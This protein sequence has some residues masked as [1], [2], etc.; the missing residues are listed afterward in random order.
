MGKRMNSDLPKV[1]HP[2][3]NPPRPMV[4]AVIDACRAAGC[5]RIVLVIGHRAEL[6]REAIAKNYGTNHTIE[7]GLQPEQLG[8]GHAVRCVENLFFDEKQVPGN[9]L[10]VLAG[11]GPLIRA[12]TLRDLLSR[13]RAAKAAA[14][15]ATSVIPDPTGYGRI[16][17]DAAGKFSAIVEHKDATPDQ[18]AIREV[19]PSYYLFDAKELFSALEFVNRNPQSGEYYITDVPGLLLQQHKTVEVIPSVPPEDVLSINTPDQLAEVDAIY[20][21]RTKSGAQRI[22]PHAM[23]GRA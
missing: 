21:S 22:E 16:V 6:V 12:E 23:G 4:C 11:D 18:R 1:L 17:R 19:N 20:Q 3:G 15:L 7:F 13:H 14:T 2:V 9:E 5:N 10:F 8:T